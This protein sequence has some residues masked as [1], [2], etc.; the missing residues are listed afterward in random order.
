MNF[1][2]R[3]CFLNDFRKGGVHLWCT[4]ELKM[5]FA[6]NDSVKFF[7]DFSL[8][9]VICPIRLSCFKF[10]E[11]HATKFVGSLSFCDDNEFIAAFGGKR[12]DVKN[13]KCMGTTLDLICCGRC[14]SWTHQVFEKVKMSLEFFKTGVV[15][16]YCNCLI[17]WNLRVSNWTLHCTGCSRRISACKNEFAKT[18]F[19]LR[20]IWLNYKI[21]SMNTK[22]LPTQLF[23]SHRNSVNNSG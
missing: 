3:W 19:A 10:N 13:I 9:L 20:R 14:V 18:L 17:Y 5:A 8:M 6:H 23:F 12:V 2:R 4:R 11:F 1:E 22:N 15:G 21:C 16:F 7:R